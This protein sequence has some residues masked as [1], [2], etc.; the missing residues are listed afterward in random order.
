MLGLWCFCGLLRAWGSPP[1][2]CG[3]LP[4][5]PFACFR[6]F[7][8][9]RA[10]MSTAGQEAHAAKRAANKI[11]QATGSSGW[12]VTARCALLPFLVAALHSCISSLQHRIDCQA[13]VC[14]LWPMY[15]PQDP[16]LV[17]A[18]PGSFLDTRGM[19]NHIHHSRQQAGADCGLGACAT[20]VRTHSS[21]HRLNPAPV[22]GSPSGAASTAQGVSG[23]LLLGRI[24]PQS[25]AKTFFQ[26]QA[27]LEP[28]TLEERG[29][30]GLTSRATGNPFA[31]A[32]RPVTGKTPPHSPNIDHPPSTGPMAR[33]LLWRP[34]TDLSA[35]TITA[36]T[37]IKGFSPWFLQGLWPAL[38]TGCVS[39]SDAAAFS[40]SPHCT[41][42][43]RQQR[44]HH[45]AGGE[46]NSSAYP[47][48][49]PWHRLEATSPGAHPS[50]ARLSLAACH[51]AQVLNRLEVSSPGPYS[52]SHE[53]DSES[54]ALPQVTT[55]LARCLPLYGRGPGCISSCDD[56][57]RSACWLAAAV[58]NTAHHLTPAAATTSQ[59]WFKHCL[60]L[61]SSRRSWPN[62]PQ[63]ANRLQ[64][65]QLRLDQL[66]YCPV[67]VC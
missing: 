16:P 33:W 66:S 23:P 61:L 10:A 3:V 63:T 49:H 1:S 28:M 37:S 4:P 2:G 14:V 30:A 59:T 5:S 55:P 29:R 47:F 18:A 64:D 52:L 36:R 46:S 20:A 45:S 57:S 39:L 24:A 48:I 58:L 22:R 34:W 67:S 62:V 7:R 35:A 38:S 43:C 44:L 40:L 51:D 15:L 26:M 42:V 21:G 25:V 32:E 6:V 50:S 56:L 12:P 8:G 54:F 31:F 13:T 65:Q 41:V 11:P 19:V 53:A 17:G 60:L 27:K 9:L